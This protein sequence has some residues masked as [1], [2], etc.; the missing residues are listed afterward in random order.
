M[1]L[2]LNPD[3]EM[4]YHF[5]PW[6]EPVSYGYNSKGQLHSMVFKAPVGDSIML[7][8]VGGDDL[9]VFLED[10]IVEEGS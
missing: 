7:N 1:R 4:G 9:V 2:V 3:R 6:V 8:T 10:Y 5:I